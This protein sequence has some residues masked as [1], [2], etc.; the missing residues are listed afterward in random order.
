M[1]LSV[2][3]QFPMAFRKQLLEQ[4]KQETRQPDVMQT[5][6][7]AMSCRVASSFIRVGHIELF[8]RRAAKGNAKAKEQ[9]DLILKH[10]IWREYPD[11]PKGQYTHT[12]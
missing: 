4:L 7:C 8:G 6:H 2:V 9:L 10:A 12:L 3:S 11:I 5:E 1:S